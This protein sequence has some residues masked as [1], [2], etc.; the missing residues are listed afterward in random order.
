MEVPDNSQAPKVKFSK[1]GKVVATESAKVVTEQKKND[2][3]AI[4]SVAGGN[5]QLVTAIRPAG[6]EES[7]VFGSAGHNGTATP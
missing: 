4:E 7:L 1:N 5:A 6:W 3:T 2:N